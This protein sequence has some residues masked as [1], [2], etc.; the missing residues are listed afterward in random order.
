MQGQIKERWEALCE[1]AAT[2]QVS[3]P[4]ESSGQR[5]QLFEAFFNLLKILIRQRGPELVPFCVSSV[6]DSF[7]EP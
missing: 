3:G 2:E 7:S 4:E 1:Q 6:H 5:T